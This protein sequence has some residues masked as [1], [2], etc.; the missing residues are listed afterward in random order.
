MHARFLHRKLLTAAAAVCLA[1]FFPRKMKLKGALPLMTFAMP[2]GH[3][4]CLQFFT[5]WVFRTVFF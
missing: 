1:P 5:P 3:T 2:F 4:L